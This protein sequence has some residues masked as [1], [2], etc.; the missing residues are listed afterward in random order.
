MRCGVSTAWRRTWT[1]RRSTTFAAISIEP[2]SLLE[3]LREI[4]LAQVAEVLVGERIEFVLE[5]RREHP[6]DLFLPFLLLEP[7]VVEQLFG[8]A[9]VFVVELDADIAWQPVRIGIRAREPDELGLGNGHPLALER[10]VVRSLL[11]HRVDVVAPRVVVDE[12]V[13]REPVLL[14][15]PPRQSPDAAGRLA[16][17]GQKDA[18]VPAPEF[19]LR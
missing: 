15:Q 7:A 2:V 14:V 3:L 12:N 4:G 13:N 5:T 10:E 8:P 1:P 18:V 17:A 19:I 11:D 9:H 6:L 16:V